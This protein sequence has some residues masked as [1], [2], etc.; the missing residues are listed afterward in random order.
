VH[1]FVKQSGGHITIVS[2]ANAGTTVKLY[3]PRLASDAGAGA[4]DRR[5]DAN[6]LPRSANGETILVVEDEPEVRR[7][8]VEML[9]ELGY[10]TLDA[11]DAA[12]ALH[13]LD[14]HPEIALLFTDVV[15]PGKN[16]RQLADEARGL[17]PH[18]AVLFT[19]GYSRNTIVN[20][21]DP[22]VQ[23][24][25]KPHTLEMLAQKV[26]DLLHASRKLQH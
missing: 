3:L 26:A 20:H 17:R 25:A 8:A 11:G 12:E 1:G 2:Q 18:L 23:L 21:G 24:V 15:M 22:G 6:P 16:G 4:S 9:Q 14:E 19:T 13:I 5:P 7:L 10:A